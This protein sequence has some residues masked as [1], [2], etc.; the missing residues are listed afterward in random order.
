MLLR[1]ACCAS[2][3]DADFDAGGHRRRHRQQRCPARSDAEGLA[4]TRESLDVRLRASAAG[5]PPHRR[6]DHPH[7]RRRSTAATCRPA[8]AAHRRAAWPTSCPTGRNFY[9]VDPRSIPSTTAW[10]VGTDLARGRRRPLPPRG[11]RHPGERRH[12]DLGHH[13]DAHLRRRHRPGAG[14]ARRPAGLAAGEPPRRRRRGDPA[15]GARPAAHRCGLPHLRLLP[16]R[17]PARHLAA[18]RRVRA[19]LEAWTSRSSRTSCAPTGSPPTT[20]CAP[21]AW[22]RPRRGGGPA[23]ASSGASPAPTARASSS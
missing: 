9:S 23:T 1:A 2:L 16:R 3:L 4:L 5:A 11:R 6:G 21:R 7:P 13:R 12:L 20:A 8:R 14:A 17:L 19:R 18:G 15:R 22:T 10:L